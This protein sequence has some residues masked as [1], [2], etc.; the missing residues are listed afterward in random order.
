MNQLSFEYVGW[1]RLSYSEPDLDLV[2]KQVVDRCFRIQ[3]WDIAP[4]IREFSEFI[5]FPEYAGPYR[6]YGGKDDYSFLEKALEHFLS[7]KIVQPRRGQVFMDVGSCVSVVPEILRRHYGCR[8]YAQD[9]ELPAGIAGWN[10]G[11]NAAEIPLPD[12]SLDGMTLHCTFEHFE[13]NADSA[14]IREC[15][16]LLKPGGKTVILPLYVN[17]NWTNITGETDAAQR[18]SIGCD[19]SASYWCVIPEW[20][21]RFG[22]HYSAQALLDRVLDV[23]VGCG[24]QVEI[25]RVR[26]FG[27]I[28]PNLWLRWVLVLQRL[29]ADNWYKPD[30]TLNGVPR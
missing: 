23:A 25:F 15:A 6:K 13:G 27:Q 18:S 20:Q 10:V 1:D 9:L 3:T 12:S 16:R 11:G 7:F 22:R 24:L 29:K 17:T 5:K 4:L 21:N 14:F 26:N 28:H 8:C 2:Q 30:A 19:G